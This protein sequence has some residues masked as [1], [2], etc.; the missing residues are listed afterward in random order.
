ME[1]LSVIVGRV[2]ADVRP[3][4]D[5]EEWGAGSA[6]RTS[7]AKVQPGKGPVADEEG[8]LG[9]RSCSGKPTEATTARGVT[10]TRAGWEDERP[11]PVKAEGRARREECSRADETE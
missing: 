8:N 9:R 3:S 11:R 5:N 1:R 4:N 7:P 6:L 2:L 10:G